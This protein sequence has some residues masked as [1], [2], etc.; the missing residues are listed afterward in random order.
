MVKKIRWVG[1]SSISGELA[2]RG[3]APLSFRDFFSPSK[4]F[5]MTPASVRGRQIGGRK[6]D[7][8]IQRLGGSESRFEQVRRA[9]RLFLSDLFSHCIQPP[10]GGF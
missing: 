7:C 2:P 1:G 9:C 5:G 8:I 3:P 10:I 4:I 6:N